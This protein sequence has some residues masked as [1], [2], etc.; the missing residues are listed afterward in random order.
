MGARRY[1][2]LIGDLVHSRRNEARA[3][4]QASLIEWLDEVAKGAAREI[5][6]ARP[7]LT[8]GDEIQCLFARP[9]AAMDLIQ[10]LTDRLYG[11]PLRQRIAFGLGWGTLSTT[12][13]HA[14]LPGA[15]DRVSILDGECF[16]L[17]RE[18]LSQARQTRGWVVCQG[19][20]SPFD[21][22][23]TSLFQLMGTIRGEWTGTQAWLTYARRNYQTQKETAEDAD[24]L[25]LEGLGKRIGASAISQSLQAAHLN[26]ILAGE[27]AVRELLREAARSSTGKEEGGG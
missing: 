5:Y 24:G 7:Q 16:H 23:L 22:G 11:A 10:E 1:L 9:E 6:A 13:P 21:A 3:E 12:G 25:V 8:A 4:V 26:A 2:T 15:Y 19:F 14:E 18:A 20:P 17:A 27:D